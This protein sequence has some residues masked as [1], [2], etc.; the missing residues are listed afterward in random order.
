MNLAASA[1]LQFRMIFALMLRRI[2]TR[3]SSSRA[4]YLWAIAEP[5]IWIFVL[6]F[7]LQGADSNRPPLG[8]SYEVFFATGIIIAL[9][10]RTVSSSV[11]AAV[12]RRGK[13]TLPAVQQMDAAYAVWILELTTGLLAKVIILAAI[14]VFGHNVIPDNFLACLASYIALALFSLGFG[15]TFALLLTVAPGLIHFKRVII[16]AVFFTSGFSFLVDRIPPSFRAI[17]V[18]NPLVHCIEWFREGFY[19]GYVCASL[20][21]VY[22]F[23]VTIVLLLIGLAGE[24]AFRNYTPPNNR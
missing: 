8:T 21:R 1:A 9:S 5:I 16:L 24:R 3:Y 4:G 12:V 23:A 15:L 11:T 14:G 17:V 22:L 19:A 6:K 18:W 10:W 13:R 20:D 7:G 2:K